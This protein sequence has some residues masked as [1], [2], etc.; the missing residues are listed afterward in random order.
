[1]DITPRQ[2]AV[3]CSNR[4]TT[5]EV[6]HAAAFSAATQPETAVGRPAWYLKCPAAIF[7]TYY[8][9]GSM[10]YNMVQQF[11]KRVCIMSA[12]AAAAAADPACTSLSAPLHPRLH[13]HLRQQQAATRAVQP[14][15]Q[16]CAAG[17]A[18]QLLCSAPSSPHVVHCNLTVKP[19]ASL[20]TQSCMPHMLPA[21]RSHTQARQVIASE[22]GIVISKQWQWAYLQS[23]VA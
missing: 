21:A 3:L 1:M 19:T 12:Q 7:Y 20:V 6:K 17:S 2:A 4:R 10:K 22:T 23:V 9:A 14:S 13:N 11:L 15:F 8:M 16:G 5:G 18:G